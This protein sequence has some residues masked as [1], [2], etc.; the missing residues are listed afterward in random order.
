M[1]IKSI[2]DLDLNNERLFLRVDFNVPIRN[3]KVD[4][5]TRIR[6]AMQTIEFAKNSGAKIIL[7]SH[8]GRPKGERRKEYSLKSV[9]DYI[10]E[11]FF[12]IGFVD[13][14]IGEE[15]ERKV[16]TLNSGEILLLEN[17]RFHKGEEKND[18]EFVNALSRFVDVYVNDA[19]GTCHRKHASVYGLPLKIDKRAA[20]FLIEKEVKVFDK[21]LTDPERPFVAILGGAKISD[22]IGVINSLLDKID[23]L[24]IGGAMAYTFLKFN[25][26]KVGKSLVEEDMLNTVGDIVKKAESK[27]VKIYLPV[28]HIASESPEGEPKAVDS[29]NI[30]DNLMGLD[31]GIKTIS[32]FKDGLKDAKTILWNGP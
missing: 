18:P 25:G 31:I 15:V 30:D 5:D 26:V 17:L 12:K 20:G 10:S 14:C 21:I 29:A 4:D 6:E 3:G 2:K 22:K 28:D 19:F 23:R 13:D 16:N 9:A 1:R 11:N 24:F 27:G 7:A 32:L 8:L